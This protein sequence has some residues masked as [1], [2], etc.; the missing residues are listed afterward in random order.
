MIWEGWE[1]EIDWE[2]DGEGGVCGLRFELIVG[3]GLVM[4]ELLVKDAVE[5]RDGVRGGV[6]S[7][8]GLLA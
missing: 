6:E 1:G 3:D 8:V 4:D 5:V 2:R 7:N